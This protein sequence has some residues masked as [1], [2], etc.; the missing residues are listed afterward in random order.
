M[1]RNL[2]LPA[3]PATMRRE[4]AAAYLSVSPNTLSKIGIAS[5]PHRNTDT[6]VYRKTDLDAYID[7]LGRAGRRTRDDD[8]DLEAEGAALDAKLCG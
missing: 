4:M 3:W 6:W 5:Y 7:K 8:P 2:D 1:A